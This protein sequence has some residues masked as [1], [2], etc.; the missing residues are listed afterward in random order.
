MIALDD[1]LL[2]LPRP[3]KRSSSSATRSRSPSPSASHPEND[4]PHIR[5]IS[6]ERASTPSSTT[7]KQPAERGRSPSPAT[8]FDSPKLLSA[9]DFVVANRRLETLPRRPR[10]GSLDD[11][12][13]RIRNS[14]EVRCNDIDLLRPHINDSKAAARSRSLSPLPQRHAYSEPVISSK[15]SAP[16]QYTESHKPQTRT[17]SLRNLNDYHRRARLC[18]SPSSE[19]PDDLALTSFLRSARSVLSLKKHRNVPSLAPSLATTESSTPPRTSAIPECYSHQKSEGMSALNRRHTHAPTSALKFAASAAERSAAVHPAVMKKTVRMHSPFGGTGN[20][21]VLA[22][23]GDQGA[24]G[25][26]V[27]V[28]N[29]TARLAALNTLDPTD[30]SHMRLPKSRP[31]D[32]AVPFDSPLD[33]VSSTTPSEAVHTNSTRANPPTPPTMFP[34][35]RSDSSESIG[36]VMSTQW[37]S[38]DYNLMQNTWKTSKLAVVNGISPAS[39]GVPSPMPLRRGLLPGLRTE[40]LPYIRDIISGFSPVPEITISNPDGASETSDSS[41][42]KTGALTTTAHSDDTS[43]VIVQPSASTT[44]K[45]EPPRPASAEL[46]ASFKRRAFYETAPSAEFHFPPPPSSP[47]PPAALAAAAASSCGSLP[48]C[49]PPLPPPRKES[50]RYDTMR[51]TSTVEAYKNFEASHRKEVEATRTE[52]RKSLSPGYYV[53]TRRS[54]TSPSSM[55]TLSP[56]AAASSRSSP[57][58]IATFFK[59]AIRG[60]RKSLPTTRPVHRHLY[61][62]RPG[63]RSAL[64]LRHSKLPLPEYL[65]QYAEHGAPAANVDFDPIKVAGEQFK[66]TART[67]ARQ[68]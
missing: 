38:V 67:R 53:D 3:D 44:A 21:A 58:R 20:P 30:P 2:N 22:R 6:P 36:S 62:T 17:S 13:R 61:A 55:S 19:I 33:S 28:A 32:H 43:D 12:N 54:L 39:S 1:I 10:R 63:A 60:R 4:I 49:P 64:S 42:T 50:A 52:R 5:L 35:E 56:Q 9:E 40:E 25:S 37:C 57:S 68:A 24:G 18:D 66:Q 51:P 31:I 59:Q 14:V 48:S 29:V 7:D 41:A 34:I 46:P 65:M 8:F 26:E 27:T 15:S 16:A 47:P 23:G 45:S 11:R